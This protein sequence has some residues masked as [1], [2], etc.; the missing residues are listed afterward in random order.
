MAVAADKKLVT[1]LINGGTIDLTWVKQNSD[2]ILEAWYPGQ[3]GGEA[4]AAVLLGE[5][6]P[7][8]RLP[9]T[10]YDSDVVTS[11]NI[12]VR[13]KCEQRTLLMKSSIYAEESH[14]RLLLV[15]LLLLLVLLLV[16]L[17]GQIP[18]DRSLLTDVAVAC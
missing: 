6:A 14:R 17:L 12:T 15:L 11:R 7:S 1:V 16:L 18:A 8:G 13:E 10:L 9:V 4:V 2:A 5:A 3:A